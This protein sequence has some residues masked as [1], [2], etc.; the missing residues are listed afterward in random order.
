L[1]LI[2]L[3][4]LDYLKLHCLVFAQ[5]AEALAL[6]GA[7]M[8]EDI[9]A[10]IPGDKAKALGIIKPFYR[11]SFLHGKTSFLMLQRYTRQKSRAHS[12]QAK[13]IGEELA[14]LSDSY[15]G[16][17]ALIHSDMPNFLYFTINFLIVKLI[18]IKL[19]IFINYKGYRLGLT[20]RNKEIIAQL[21]LLLWK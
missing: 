21:S 15:P 18:K 16:L 8:H 19:D 11:T 6:D 14:S 10:A 13:K 20:D 4:T 17:V 5:G 12:S 3:G 1:G 7:V 2:A 9:G